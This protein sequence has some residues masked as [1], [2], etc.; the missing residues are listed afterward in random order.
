MTRRIVIVG[1]G[2]A[3]FAMS[4][5]RTLPAAAQT[6]TGAAPAA[7]WT[8]GKTPDGQPDIQGTWLFFDQTPLEKPGGIP[9]RRRPGETTE[10][11]GSSDQLQRTAAARRVATGG[12]AA[13]EFYN[14]GPI[15][16]RS[17]RRQS[18]VVVPADGK[19]P[20]RP[21]AV[22]ARD[23]NLDYFYDS[24]VYQTAAERCITYGIPGGMFPSIN[25]SVR[26]I[27][28]PGYVAIINES[29]NGARIIPVDGRPHL[30]PQIHL[31]N[32]DSRGHW[33]G[34]TLV[35][36]TTNYNNKAAVTHFADHLQG[37]KQSEALHLVERFT[38]VS[39]N[40]INYEVTIDDPNVYTQ[41][42]KVELPYTRNDVYKAFEYA[43]HEGNLHYMTVSLGSGRFKD[44]G[45]EAEKNLSAT[46]KAAE[47]AGLD[48][49]PGSK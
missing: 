26:I 22:K 28:G 9:T 20:V 47:E 21:E 49:K 23:S 19:V 13:N 33:E 43:C 11:A 3:A 38:P 45:P 10:N 7:G 15:V 32:G 34:N 30:P 5:A 44:R 16:S 36:D 25:A 12:N 4:V 17:A 8:I 6:T 29:M 42:W 27:E 48:R 1:L 18:L 2:A 24:Y 39:P 40:T 37:I 46:R 35:V 14:E 41:P 31:W